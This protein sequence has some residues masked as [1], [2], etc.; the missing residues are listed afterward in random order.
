MMVLCITKI[1]KKLKHKETEL[2]N[3]IIGMDFQDNSI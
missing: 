1:L 3:E 2:V